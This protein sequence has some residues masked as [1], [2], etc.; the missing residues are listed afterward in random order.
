MSFFVRGKECDPKGTFSHLLSLDAILDCIDGI[1]KR[2]YWHD[3]KCGLPTIICK[4][5]PFLKHKYIA[6]KDQP[7]LDIELDYFFTQM[8]DLIW[9]HVLPKGGKAKYSWIDFSKYQPYLFL[10]T[11]N[12]TL[13]P[14][15]R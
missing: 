8:E 4:T 2:F 1:S 13:S 14:L 10:W 5:S 15:R 9:E 3:C 7:Q 6:I 12:Q 11:T